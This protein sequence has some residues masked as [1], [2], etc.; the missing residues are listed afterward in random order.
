MTSLF[1][2][3]QMRDPELFKSTVTVDDACKDALVP[4]LLLL[5]LAEN[6][7]KHGPARGHRGAVTVDIRADEGSVVVVVENPGAFAGRRDGGEGL[8]IVEGRTALVG[9]SVVVETV[10]G[11]RTRATLRLPRERQ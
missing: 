4:P 3:H 7:M 1:A 6:A 5:P 2:L 8:A 11:D 10:G 9:G